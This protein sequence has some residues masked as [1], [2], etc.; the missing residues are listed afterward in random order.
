VLAV[1]A[2][3]G[4]GGGN[5]RAAKPGATPAPKPAASPEQF[6]ERFERLTSVKLDPVPDPFGVRMDQPGEPDLGYRFSGYTY[7]WTGDES[8]RELR[9][10]GALVL[11]AA[12]DELGDPNTAN[13]IF[14]MPE[15]FVPGGVNVGT[16]AGECEVP[17]IGRRIR[18]MLLA[19]V[20][21]E[22]PRA[23]GRVAGLAERQVLLADCGPAGVWA[24]L[25]WVARGGPKGPTIFVDEFELRGGTWHG[26]PEG[27]RPGCGLPDA[28]AAAWQIDIS[29]CDRSGAGGPPGDIS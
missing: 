16:R 12:A 2:V 3:A 11:P 22:T 6:A 26:S 13:T 21:S 1:L 18:T 27:R 8:D 4:C 7:Y 10:D 15:D 24:L 23:K 20:R 17:R 5:E 9:R 29:H 14:P 28:A 19:T 25:S